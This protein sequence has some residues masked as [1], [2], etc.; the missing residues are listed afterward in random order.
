MF[1]IQLAVFYSRLVRVLIPPSL[2]V[3]LQ[4]LT[5]PINWPRVWIIR[6]LPFPELVFVILVLETLAGV[7]KL[8]FVFRSFHQVVLLQT[9]HRLNKVFVQVCTYSVFTINPVFVAF[10][11]VC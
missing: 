8:P 9:R 1:R 4:S 3:V 6:A 11:E 7:V 10:D 5:N 2:R